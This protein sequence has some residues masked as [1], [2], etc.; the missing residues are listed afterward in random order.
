MGINLATAISPILLHKTRQLQ[1]SST[2]ELSSTPRNDSICSPKQRVSLLGQAR[3]AILGLHTSAMPLGQ[4]VDLQTLAV[5][6]HGYSGS[7]LAALCREAGLAA[8]S[9][10]TSTDTAKQKPHNQVHLS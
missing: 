9:R 5:V 6:T 10:D 7:D 8:L 4:D 3:E 2:S 1:N